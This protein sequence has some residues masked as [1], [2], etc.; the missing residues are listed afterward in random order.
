MIKIE[1]FPRPKVTVPI[2]ILFICAN[3]KEPAGVVPNREK[4]IW[5]TKKTE[6]LPM[7]YPRIL[8]AFFTLNKSNGRK[9]KRAKVFMVTATAM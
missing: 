7:V 1:A 5:E 6:R 8:K 3:K 4:K 2:S 9:I